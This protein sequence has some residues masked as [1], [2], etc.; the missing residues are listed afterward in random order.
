MMRSRLVVL[1]GSAL[2][3]QEL[4]ELLVE[5]VGLRD[6]R[7]GLGRVLGHAAE[8]QQVAAGPYGA[9]IEPLDG[10]AEAGAEYGLGTAARVALWLVGRGPRRGPVGP[11]HL[12]GARGQVG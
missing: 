8:Q 4:L 2:G 10:V 6:G 11:P 9:E 3:A 12:Q 1:T 5:V 7:I